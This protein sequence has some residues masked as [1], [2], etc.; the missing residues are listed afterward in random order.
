MDDIQ[1]TRHELYDLVWAEPLSRLAKKYNISDN[2]LR[3]ICKKMNIPMPANGYWQK[4]HH[5]KSVVKENLPTYQGKDLITLCFRDSEGNYVEKTESPDSILK[6]EF[7][8]DSKLSFRVS[9]R[10][11]NPDQLVIQAQQ[12]LTKDKR[13]SQPYNG[14]V[15]TFSGELNIRVSP[16]KVSRALRFMDAFI[17]LVRARK[18]DITNSRYGKICV[19]IFGVESEIL[20]KEKM[21]I[22]RPQDKYGLG[23]QE[24]QPTGI[25]SFIID[26]Y[27]RK[28]WTDSKQLIEDKLSDILVYL[29][30]KSNKILQERIEDERIRQIRAEEERKKMEFLALK[31]KELNAFED[32]F[33]QALRW[34]QAR[35]MRDYLSTV[36]ENEKCNLT[37]DTELNDWINWAKQKIDWYD[38]L[39]KAKDDLLDDTDRKKLVE[40]VNPQKKDTTTY[41]R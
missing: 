37:T 30:L 7:L 15:T 13:G 31:H 32:L 40:L 12:T 6:K 27:P 38:P 17:K 9:D 20:L 16:S 3:K 34:Q 8:G 36:I 22:F 4:I 25:F 29:E 2:G 21:K 19:V 24:F 39:I 33:N 26:S 23:P 28:E 35:F 41:K 18:H 1:L 10:L 5:Q 14:V 11:T